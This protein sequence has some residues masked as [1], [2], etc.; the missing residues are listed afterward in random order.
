MFSNKVAAIDLA[1]GAKA[2]CSAQFETISRGSTANSGNCRGDCSSCSTCSTS[3][4]LAR[5]PRYTI[6][7]IPATTSDAARSDVAR[8]TVASSHSPA[9][10][11]PNPSMIEPN[12]QSLSERRRVVALMVSPQAQTHLPELGSIFAFEPS[13]ERL[14]ACD[15]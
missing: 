3:L 8:K 12:S 7:P 5:S 2:L 6:T 11:V 4:R 15:I 9:S 1:S 13:C 14:S 10:G